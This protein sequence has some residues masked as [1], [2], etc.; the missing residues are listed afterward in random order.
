M[1]GVS[2]VVGV[3]AL[4]E[5]P[6][7]RYHHMVSALK[8]SRRILL[9]LW[10]LRSPADSNTSDRELSDGGKRIDFIFLANPQVR[11]VLKPVAFRTR[12]LPDSRVGFLSD[13]CAVEAEF[14][15]SER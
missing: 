1:K 2:A 3:I 6:N 12:R 9:D 14:E 7:S 4:I 10:T 11:E 5:N 15:W 8:Q 13:H